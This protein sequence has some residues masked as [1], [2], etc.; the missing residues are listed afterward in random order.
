MYKNHWFE[1]FKMKKYISS[2]FICLEGG[3]VWRN[4]LRNTIADVK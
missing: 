3:W 2:F 1:K 4:N